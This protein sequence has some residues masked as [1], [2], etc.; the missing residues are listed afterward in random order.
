MIKRQLKM[1]EDGIKI[2][3]IILVDYMR[4]ILNNTLKMANKWFLDF[5]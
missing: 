5:S 4:E 1:K 2:K 3:I